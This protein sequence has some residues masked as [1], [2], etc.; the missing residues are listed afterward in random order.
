[1]QSCSPTLDRKEVVGAWGR[2]PFENDPAA[3]FVIDVQGA[4]S[5]DVVRVGLLGAT[6]TDGY[7]E[8]DE[9]SVAIAAAEVVAAARG[10]AAAS[11]PEAVAIWLVDH[12]AEATADDVAA[13]LAAIDRV[14]RDDSE[15]RGL[16]EDV[17]DETWMQSVED[18]R[19]RLRG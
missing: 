4:T 2:G 10:N 15:L 5:F 18:L 14:S 8:V 3:D 12:A 13:A 1:M 17:G 7:L 6:G 9:G 11:L 19:A 16:W